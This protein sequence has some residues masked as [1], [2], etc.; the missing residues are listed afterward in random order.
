LIHSIQHRIN[1]D[2]QV[3][4]FRIVIGN[5]VIGSLCIASQANVLKLR[6]IARRN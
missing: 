5:A 3:P 6:S 4:P 1:L 2:L